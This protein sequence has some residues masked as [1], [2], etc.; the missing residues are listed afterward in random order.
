MSPEYAK[1]I[2]PLLQFLLLGFSED[3]FDKVLHRYYSIV[4]NDQLCY[5]NVFGTSSDTLRKYFL[6]T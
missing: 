3:I 4:C 2:S 5:Q 6:A 1:E